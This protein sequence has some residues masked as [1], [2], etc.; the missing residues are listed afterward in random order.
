VFD[1]LEDPRA[2]AKAFIAQFKEFRNN[3]LASVNHDLMLRKSQR[4]KFRMGNKGKAMFAVGIGSFLVR[5][6][7]VQL[8]RKDYAELAGISLESF[9][10]LVGKEKSIVKIEPE[11]FEND[12][13]RYN[14]HTAAINGYKPGPPAKLLEYVFADSDVRERLKDDSFAKDF[15]WTI[16]KEAASELVLPVSTNHKVFAPLEEMA[17]K[18]LNLPATEMLGDWSK[19]LQES[20]GRILKVRERREHLGADS[21]FISNCTKTWKT[22]E[23]WRLGIP[24]DIERL[25]EYDGEFG[26]YLIHVFK[27]RTEDPTEFYEAWNALVKM[28]IALYY[29]SPQLMNAFAGYTDFHKSS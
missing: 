22:L 11:Q 17:N 4:R 7:N 27:H 26:G 3:T 12:R 20:Q 21:T 8:T 2:Y 24:K 19:L 14:P 5:D 18:M 25:K 9:L 13:R 16:I 1:N 10:K 29:M 28:S 23:E 15:F 6:T